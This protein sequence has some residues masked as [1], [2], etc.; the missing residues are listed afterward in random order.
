MSFQFRCVWVQLA[1]EKQKA[2]IHG[3]NGMFFF[4]PVLVHFRYWMIFRNKLVLITELKTEFLFIYSVWVTI[5]R[6]IL[7]RVKVIKTYRLVTILTRIWTTIPIVK[8]LG[9]GRNKYCKLFSSN[10]SSFA[11]IPLTINSMS[12]ELK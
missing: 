10:G 7:T 4:S 9:N 3:L 11:N 1:L 12:G 6:N 5:L 8:M 2:P